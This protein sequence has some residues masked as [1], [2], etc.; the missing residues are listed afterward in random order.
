[1]GIWNGIKRASKAIVEGTGPAEYIVGGKRLHYQ[2]CGEAHF[3]EGRAQLNTAGITFLDIDWAN[4][5]A[6]TLMCDH[7]SLIHWFGER[8]ERCGQ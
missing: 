6:T 3:L 7:C 5:S 1:M 2:H 8:P 4:K